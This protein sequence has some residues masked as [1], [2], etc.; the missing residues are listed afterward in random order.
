[1]AQW[2]RTVHGQEFISSAVKP[3]MIQNKGH[4]GHRREVLGEIFIF[5]LLKNTV[6]LPVSVECTRFRW[7]SSRHL[8]GQF[9]Q[10]HPPGMGY[11][12]SPIFLGNLLS[13][14]PC[15]DSGADI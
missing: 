3:C 12:Q 14:T 5:L 6:L 4:R 10:G 9:N 8:Y 7:C 2:G 11:D 13:L 1:M 15:L